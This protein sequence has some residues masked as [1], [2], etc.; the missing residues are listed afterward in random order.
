MDL[1]I[2]KDSIINVLEKLKESGAIE[3]NQNMALARW[4]PE[5]SITRPHTPCQSSVQTKKTTRQT[6]A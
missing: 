2:K 1:A 5:R 4:K 6:S 3:L